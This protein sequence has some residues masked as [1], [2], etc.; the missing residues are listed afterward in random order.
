MRWIM[1]IGIGVDNN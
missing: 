1:M